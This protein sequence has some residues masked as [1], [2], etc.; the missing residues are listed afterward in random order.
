M[1]QNS[2]RDIQNS[3]KEYLKYTFYK[4]IKTLDQGQL[5]PP[6]AKEKPREK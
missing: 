4:D 3:P 6:E 2:K 5:F 1:L